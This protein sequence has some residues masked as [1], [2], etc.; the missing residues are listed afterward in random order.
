M[1]CALHQRQCFTAQQNPTGA[2]LQAEKLAGSPEA[3][4]KFALQVLQAS[5]CAQVVPAAIQG[6]SAIAA[7]A[8][9]AITK[10]VTQIEKQGKC[11]C[12]LHQQMT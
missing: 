11:L 6:T 2:P 3:A 10:S 5:M 1:A 4:E 8:T 9:A 7:T 12:I